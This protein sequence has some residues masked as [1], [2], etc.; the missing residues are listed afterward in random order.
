MQEMGNLQEVSSHKSI[1][2][3]SSENHFDLFQL[4][5]DLLQKHTRF[6]FDESSFI[7]YKV[8]KQALLNTHVIK[9]F[10]WECH[11]K[12]ICEVRNELEDAISW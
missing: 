3:K 12:L 4:L 7:A 6:R 10:I 11:F 2:D 5:A 1:N 9:Q 8:L